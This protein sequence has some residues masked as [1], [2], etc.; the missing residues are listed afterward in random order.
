MRQNGRKCTFVCAYFVPAIIDHVLCM[1]K[2]EMASQMIVNTNL[3]TNWCLFIATQ[4][5]ITVKDVGIL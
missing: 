2:K 4:F 5:E 1:S 3:G